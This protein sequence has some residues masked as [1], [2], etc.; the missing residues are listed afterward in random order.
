MCIHVRV[1]GYMYIYTHAHTDIYTQ[2]A[3][4]DGLGSTFAST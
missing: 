2:N 3:K 1:C 4:D